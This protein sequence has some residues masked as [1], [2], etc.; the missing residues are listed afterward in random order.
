MRIDIIRNRI[1]DPKMFEILIKTFEYFG[2]I[3]ND[4]EEILVKNK[5]KEGIIKLLFELIN[6]IEP[7][8]K[9]KFSENLNIIISEN[10]NYALK[11]DPKYFLGLKYN[12]Y[13]ILLFKTPHICV[14]SLFNRKILNESLT[15]DV[16][17]AIT[18]L[19][20]ENIARCFKI[21]NFTSKEEKITSD[22]LLESIIEN[23][24]FYSVNHTED[25]DISALCQLIQ[26]DLSQKTDNYNWCVI[27]SK[28]ILA[29][30]GFLNSSSVIYQV[31]FNDPEK[32]YII[33]QKLNE[34]EI[35]IYKKVAIFESVLKNILTGK[36]YDIELKHMVV[37]F[38]LIIFIVLVAMCKSD[39]SDPD[40]KLNWFEDN[41]CKNK[42]S[43]FG[44]IGLMFIFTIIF[45]FLKAK[46]N[47][48]KVEK[49]KLA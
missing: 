9:R 28:K 26:F 12:N 34:C 35:L 45:G 10:G 19:N 49:K 4:R 17:N 11:F 7:A 18:D 33:S 41:V 27:I 39:Y 37:L 3:Q 36:L 43:V 48:K 22:V 5:D 20:K 24:A 15:K 14:P 21:N 2:S 42:R 44:G 13:D 47:K 23:I 6:Y 1:K 8:I 32:K 25:K 40:L 38:S 31:R 46:M 29:S 30:Q 16:Q